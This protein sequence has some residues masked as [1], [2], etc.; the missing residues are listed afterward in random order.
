M[1]ITS[2]CPYCGKEMTDGAIES[3]RDAIYW[4]RKVE[5]DY[6]DY[7]DDSRKESVLLGKPGLFS[8]NDT[9]ARYCA[10]CRVVILPVP[11]LESFS[12]KIGRLWEGTVGKALGTLGETADRAAERREEKKTERKKKEKRE[13]DPWEV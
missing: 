6:G 10:D 5:G 12:D 8:A 9:P 11:E 7:Y 1:E 13:K 4:R 3:V 2:I